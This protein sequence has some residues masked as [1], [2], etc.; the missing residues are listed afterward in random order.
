MADRDAVD[1]EGGVER[2]VLIG[3]SL[4]QHYRVSMETKGTGRD[5]VDV[6]KAACG[7][8]YQKGFE[9]IP[10]GDLRLP[11]CPRCLAAMAETSRAE[12]VPR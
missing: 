2:W 5:V 12:G 11:R 10:A 1:P 3:D 7:Y 8:S 4:F 9:R 6:H